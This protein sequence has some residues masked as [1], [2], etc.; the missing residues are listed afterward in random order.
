MSKFEASI[1]ILV[2]N[3]KD[4]QGAESFCL[5][6]GSFQATKRTPKPSASESKKDVSADDKVR[7][8]M[9]MSLLKEYLNMDQDQ[10]GMKLTL[11]LLNTQSTFLHI[12]E[13][14]T[15]TGM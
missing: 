6:S 8:T 1:A 15:R 14:R 12:S 13:V 7:R 10:G 9:F 4:Y 3:V 11:N 5:H 2:S